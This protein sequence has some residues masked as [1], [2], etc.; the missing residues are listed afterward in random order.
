MVAA[1]KEGSTAALRTRFESCNYFSAPV[2]AFRGSPRSAGL[3]ALLGYAPVTRA[4]G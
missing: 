2:G 1:G 4:Q 3:V